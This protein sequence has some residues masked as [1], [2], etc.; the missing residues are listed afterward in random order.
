MFIL[1]VCFYN[2]IKVVHFLASVSYYYFFIFHEGLIREKLDGDRS[3]MVL[4]KFERKLFPW[5]NDF[6]RINNAKGIG[7]DE[8][9]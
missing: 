2:F 7:I 6:F 8:K 5:Q 9:K 4:L 3:R 1:I